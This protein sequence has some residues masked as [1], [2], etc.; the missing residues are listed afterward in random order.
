MKVG[1]LTVNASLEELAVER[2]DP[3]IRHSHF[4]EA[5][6]SVFLALKRVADELLVHFIPREL[7]W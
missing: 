7:D 5:V 3:N 4:T 6:I 1:I 2:L